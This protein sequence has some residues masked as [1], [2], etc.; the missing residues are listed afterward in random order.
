LIEN[1]YPTWLYQEIID[2]CLPWQGG[3]RMSFSQFHEKYTL[4][5][6][7]W[8]GIFYNVA[9]EQAITLAIQ[10]DVFWLPKE[11]KKNTSDN[12]LYLF[13]RLTGS[14][15][16]ST[17]NY[18][19]IGRVCRTIASSEFEELESKKILTIDDVYGG[20]INLVYTGQETFLAM[21]QE[22]SILNI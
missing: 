7:H 20:Q 4:H 6:S 16:V 11:I 12:S 17:G 2:N 10:W 1:F 15:Q 18:V 13:I 8:L 9:Y 19:D 5:D 3:K 22:Q 21:M 14:E